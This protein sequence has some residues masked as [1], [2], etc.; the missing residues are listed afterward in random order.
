[1]TKQ[2]KLPV[3]PAKTQISLSSAQSDQSPCCPHEET[4]GHFLASQADLSLRWAH[5]PF[6]WFCHDAAHFVRIDL[7][8]HCVSTLAGTGRQG[9]DKIGGHFGIEQEISS[10]WDLAL[11]M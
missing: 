10:P 5:M 9:E 6:C 3:R 4:L 1:M 7:T 11:G 8:S 2:T